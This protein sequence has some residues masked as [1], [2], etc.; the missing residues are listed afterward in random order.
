[1]PVHAHAVVVHDDPGPGRGQPERHRTADAASR[2]RDHGDLSVQQ[3]HGCPPAS[4]REAPY[5]SGRTRGHDPPLP[6][7]PS[8]RRG[9]HDLHAIARRVMVERGFLAAFS[10]AA[11]AEVER[12]PGAARPGPGQTHDLRSLLWASIDNDDSRDLDQLSV[13]EPMNG[14]GMKILVAVAD[15]DALVAEGSAIDEHARHNTTSVYTAGGI[16]PMLPEPPSTDPTSLGENDERLAVVVEMVVQDDGAL[17]ASAI[18]R[19]LV[20][21]HAKLAYNTVAAWLDGRAPAPAAVTA[22]RG[23]DEQLRVQERAAQALRRRRHERGALELQTIQARALFD[24]DLLAD[25]PPHEPN[26]AHALLQDL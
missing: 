17:G 2:S 19:A 12:V 8:P 15:V 3:A 26:P 22:V 1:A 13:S 20:R 24:G 21:N 14:D 10:E 16:F 23:L 11:R 6:L 4:R 18:Y 9:R 25:L 5:Y 7:M